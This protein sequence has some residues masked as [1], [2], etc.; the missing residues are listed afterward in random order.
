LKKVRRLRENMIIEIKRILMKVINIREE[1][2]LIPA[3]NYRM[4]QD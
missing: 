2:V 4:I 1:K 3:V